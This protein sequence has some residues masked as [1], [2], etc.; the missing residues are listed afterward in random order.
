MC[1]RHNNLRQSIDLYPDEPLVY[2]SHNVIIPK[3]QINLS[4]FV[5]NLIYP[6]LQPHHVVRLH[7]PGRNTAR[8]LVIAQLA[9]F[10]RKLAFHD[11]WL[12]RVKRVQLGKQFEQWVWKISRVD[13]N[14]LPVT[15]ISGI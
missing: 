2:R 3:G 8:I 4:F 7:R 5:F 14:Y 15:K 11:R 13:K 10:R 1:Q 9:L 6:I 12:A